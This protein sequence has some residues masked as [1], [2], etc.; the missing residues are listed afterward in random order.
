MGVD[1]LLA[2]EGKLMRVGAWAERPTS[3]DAIAFAF[4]AGAP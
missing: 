2:G 4:R 3:R 1:F